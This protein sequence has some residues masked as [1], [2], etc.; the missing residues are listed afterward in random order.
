[1]AAE[2]ARIRAAY[3]R[4][5]EGDRYSWL[6]PGYLLAMQ[7]IERGM[8]AVL[9]A[10]LRVPLRDA[11]I[12]EVGCGNGAWL[13]QFVRWGATPGN[14]HGVDLLPERIEQAR[15]SCAPGVHLRC[16]SATELD[17]P[18]G[19]FDV[20]LQSTVFTSILD[21]DVKRRVAAEMLRVTNPG[22]SIVWYDFLVNNPRNPDVRGIRR[23]EVERLFPGCRVDLRR[24]TL[25]PPIARRLAPLSPLACTL[26]GA[27]PF[28]RTHYLGVIRRG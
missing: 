5:V 24:T 15:R 25:A 11:R 21:P 19:A 8:L 12:L 13:Q 2:E 16:G 17:Y 14:V 6:E 7:E 10:N 4:R 26:V 3:G 18:D 20:V 28:L 1:V 27:V 9:R 22:G 23:A